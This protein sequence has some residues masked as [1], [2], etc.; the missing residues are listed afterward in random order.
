MQF[1]SRFGAS[2]GFQLTGRGG[3]S[4]I[5]RPC[6]RGWTPTRPGF[7]S[8]PLKLRPRKD[9]V[10][11]SRLTARV[12]QSADPHFARNRR[13]SQPSP[14]FTPLRFHLPQPLPAPGREESRVVVRVPPPPE[15]HFFLK[16][17]SSSHELP[18]RLLAHPLTRGTAFLW[19]LR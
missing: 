18:A 8:R 4:Q 1:S 9:S 19:F 2:R 11:P 13:N 3:S 12:E 10:S 17:P 15:F 5:F 14:N 7:S 6:S 16:S